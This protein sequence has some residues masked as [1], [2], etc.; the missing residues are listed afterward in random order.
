[1][2]GPVLPTVDRP[3][4]AVPGI[5]RPGVQRYRLHRSWDGSTAEEP[6]CVVTIQFDTDSAE[7][8]ESLVETVFSRMGEGTPGLCY[9]HFLVRKDGGRVLNYGAFTDAEAHE[10]ALH[11]PDTEEPDEI[12][13]A[14]A[15]MTGVT[16]LGF[17]RYGL[18]R[19]LVN[20]G[21]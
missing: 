4:A 14:I 7:T 13:D 3:D 11:S 10:A 5:E 6:G 19:S 15:A 12:L 17:T 2:N 1:M 9:A 18:R 20:P 16:P 21:V 8:A